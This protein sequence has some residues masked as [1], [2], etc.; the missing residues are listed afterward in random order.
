MADQDVNGENPGRGWAQMLQQFFHNDVTI[1]NRGVSGRSS[2]SFINENRWDSVYKDL[3]NGDYV[4]IQFGH[5]DQKETDPKRYTNPHTAYRHNLM[6][7]VTQTR[8]KGA[9]PIL[10][11]SISRRKFNDNGTLI[12]TL[13]TYPLETRLVA[14]ELDVA[15]IDIQYYTEKLEE[16]YGPEKSKELHLHYK[17]GAIKKYPEGIEDNT[18]LSPKGATEIAQIVANQLKQL[19]LPLAKKIK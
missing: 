18:H 19:E 12:N 11:T 3:N 17:P 5:N 10:L 15:F 16:S 6:Q 8:E 2:R 7:F 4:L 1:I 13:G 14:Q 9:T